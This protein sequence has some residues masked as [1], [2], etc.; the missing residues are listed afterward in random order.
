MM[1]ISISMMVYYNSFGLQRYLLN[2]WMLLG[3][4]SLSAWLLIA[5]IPLIS[6][7]LKNLRW[8]KNKAQFILLIFSLI[9]IPLL[10]F[11]AAPAIISIYILLSVLMP[12]VVKNAS[13][14][15]RLAPEQ[16]PFLNELT[17]P[18]WQVILTLSQDQLTN[19]ISGIGM[20]QKANDGFDVYDGFNMPLFF[21]HYL[22]LNHNKKEGKDTYS[23][24]IVPTTDQFIWEFDIESNGEGRNVKIDWDN[25]Y[26]GHNDKELYLWDVAQQRAIDMRTTSTYQFDKQYSRS[27]KVIFGPISFIKKEVA[28]EEMVLHPVWPNPALENV[29]ISFTLPESSASQQVDFSLTDMVGKKHWSHQETFGSGYHEVTWRRDEK[30]EVGI[31]LI[32]LQSGTVR[33]QVKVIVK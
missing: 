16:I 11:A 25:S 5:E 26:F 12:P 18:D 1:I 3:I 19:Q 6:L 23:K 30:A 22:R 2:P 10:K 15:G 27:F 14:N 21:D 13:V 4:A 33:K 28:V 17:K 7:K 20:N 8:E 31:Y 9:L 32:Q 24:D 29:T